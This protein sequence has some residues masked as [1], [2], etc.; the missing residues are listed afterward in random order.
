MSAGVFEQLLDAHA[1]VRTALVIPT[2]GGRRGNP[3]LVD[4]AMFPHV[5][6]LTGDAGAHGFCLKDM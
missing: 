2:H 6:G 3:V 5:A 4:R 1:R